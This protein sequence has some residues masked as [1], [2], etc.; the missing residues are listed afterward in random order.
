[1]NTLPSQTSMIETALA[2]RYGLSLASAGTQ[3]LAYWIFGAHSSALVNHMDDQSSFT[4]AVTPDLVLEALEG[5]R[6]WLNQA[7]AKVRN[8]K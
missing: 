5:V 2:S 7:E 1:M 3:A 4:A 8:S 6:Y